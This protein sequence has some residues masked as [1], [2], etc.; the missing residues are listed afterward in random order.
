MAAQRT[1]IMQSQIIHKLTQSY[2]QSLMLIW[3]VC[4]LRACNDQGYVVAKCFNV[5]GCM[6][7]IRCCLGGVSKG[8]GKGLRYKHQKKLFLRSRAGDLSHV[9]F[10]VDNSNE[11]RD[12]TWSVEVASDQIANISAALFTMRAIYKLT[13]SHIQSVM[14]I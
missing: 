8:H 2:S 1:A 5:R 4:D 12:P 13:R 10:H 6:S 9:R 14:L 3:R 11:V 7:S